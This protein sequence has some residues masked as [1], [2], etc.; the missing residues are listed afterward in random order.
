MQHSM[1]NRW[2]PNTSLQNINWLPVSK[3]MSMYPVYL[4][5]KM[6]VVLVDI[7]CPDNVSLNL[8]EGQL[9]KDSKLEVMTNVGKS[10]LY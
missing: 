7:P 4:K 2:L 9:H 3:N 1:L 10:H 5:K 6:S 8:L